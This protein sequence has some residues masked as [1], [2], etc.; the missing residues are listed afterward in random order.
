MIR[1]GKTLQGLSETS[2]EYIPLAFSLEPKQ[3]P[4][5]ECRWI[6]NGVQLGVNPAFG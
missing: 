2:R 4:P 6:N 5:F 3:K 1:S